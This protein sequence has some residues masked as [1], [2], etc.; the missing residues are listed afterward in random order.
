MRWTSEL[1]KERLIEAYEI[2]RRLP[3]RYYTGTTS[4]PFPVR[5]SFADRVGWSDASERISRQ[6]ERGTVS[7]DEIERMDEAFAWLRLLL[8]HQQEQRCLAAW[9]CLKAYHRPLSFMQLR[10]PM[11]RATIY[12]FVIRGSERIAEHLNNHLDVKHLRQL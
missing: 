8:Q 7:S 1:V 11:S 6:W 5:H 3:S 4:W 10:T 2:D 12:R 9:A